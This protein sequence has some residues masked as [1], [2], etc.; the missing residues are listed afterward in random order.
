M[1]VTAVT[2]DTPRTTVLVS[3]TIKHSSPTCRL[4]LRYFIW[5]SGSHTF[6]TSLKI[7]QLIWR[8]ELNENRDTSNPVGVCFR[9]HGVGWHPTVG[10]G[11]ANWWWESS[12]MEARELQHPQLEGGHHL[13]GPYLGPFPYP[14]SF[15][16]QWRE[17]GRYVHRSDGI[18][19]LCA[20]R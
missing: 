8:A 10:I 4:R 19:R 16:T 18:P 5:D 14:A 1:A 17:A 11:V 20:A 15:Q 6:K 13:P 12:G 9:L 3:P 7:D 2:S